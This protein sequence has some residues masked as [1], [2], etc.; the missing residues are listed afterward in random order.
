M[1][2]IVKEIYQKSDRQH[3]DS[4]WYD[5][6]IATLTM[7]DKEGNKREV[8][9]YAVGDI[10]IHDKEG[11]LVFDVKARNGGFP[12]FKE[13]VPTTDKE[14]SKV[15]KLGYSWENNNWFS[16]EY[17]LNGGIKHDILGEYEYVYNEAFK[18]A[19]GAL[20]DN[21]FWKQMK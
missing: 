7:I 3:Q 13:G 17:R 16:F 14:L 8:I 21:K 1:N 11:E 6:H 19:V 18:Y 2:K 10:R 12:E 4:F 20:Q 9:I 15:E 5:G